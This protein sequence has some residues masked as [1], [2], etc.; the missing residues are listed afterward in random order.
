[1]RRRGMIKIRRR[2][3]FGFFLSFLLGW[4]AA[5]KSVEKYFF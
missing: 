3:L 2:R 1:V 5:K 4:F